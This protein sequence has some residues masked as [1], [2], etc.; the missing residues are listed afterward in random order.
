META[1]EAAAGIVRKLA[2][3][4]VETNVSRHVKALAAEPATGA[5]AWS[6]A[7]T[8]GALAIWDAGMIAVLAAGGPARQPV[9]RCASPDAG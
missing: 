7:W 8:A 3:L 5:A 9:P 4:T 6:A 2:D 1:T